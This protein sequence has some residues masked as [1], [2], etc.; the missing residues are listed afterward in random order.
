MTGEEIRKAIALNNDIIEKSVT[1]TFVLN[2]R[3]R[4][5]LQAN[6]RLRAVC[7]HEYHDGICIYCD[8]EQTT[9]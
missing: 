4:D 9:E 8:K 6:A 2:K 3:A 5:A 1:N 7:P